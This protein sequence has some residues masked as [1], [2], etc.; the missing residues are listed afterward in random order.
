ML[1]CVAEAHVDVVAS[2]MAVVMAMVE[3][4]GKVVIPARYTDIYSTFAH[5]PPCR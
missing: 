1:R 4:M 5:D 2:A 3:A